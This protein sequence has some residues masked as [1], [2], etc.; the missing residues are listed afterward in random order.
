ME[1]K[2]REFVEALINESP[3]LRAA[4]LQSIEEYDGD[5]L[6]NL[7]L[8]DLGIEIVREFEQAGTAT[9][10]RIF[11]L[12]ES[13]MGDD[14]PEGEF[15]TALAT[16]LIEAV[17]GEAERMNLWQPIS[18]SLGKLSRAYIDAWFEQQESIARTI[19]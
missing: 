18:E 9:N 5:D 10:Q 14:D 16:G 19:A 4:Y 12:I 11:A 13:G 3:G 8:G 15:G 2:T 1:S 7:L 6:P 17:V